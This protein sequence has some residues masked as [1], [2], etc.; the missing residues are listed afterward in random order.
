MQ[1]RHELIIAT[2]LVVMI[3]FT[4]EY[5][6]AQSPSTTNPST[7]NPGAILI[8]NN[9]QAAN[10]ET[11]EPGQTEEGQTGEGQTGDEAQMETVSGTVTYRQRIALPPNAKLVVK[12]EDISRADA[13]STVIAEQTIVTTGQ[14]VPIPFTLIYDPTQIDPR[15][16]YTVRAQIFYGDRLRW[17]STKINPVINQGNS[18]GVEI[19]LEQVR[20]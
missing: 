6:C 18:T 19:Q 4:A 15:G 11:G 10:G 13:P 3:G 9:A 2:P 12:L 8:A 17:T 1:V 20:G 7:T 16:R 14:Q 5:G